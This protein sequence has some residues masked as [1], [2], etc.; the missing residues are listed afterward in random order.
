M[1][2][3][4]ILDIDGSIAEY[5]EDAIKL[6][7]ERDPKVCSG[8]PDLTLENKCIRRS[9]CEKE[10]VNI[11]SKIDEIFTPERVIGFKPIKKAQELIFRAK[12]SGK[13]TLVYYVSGRPGNLIFA[14]QQWLMD[15]RFP[16]GLI[17]LLGDQP[18]D[19]GENKV[20]FV[21]KIL[22]SADEK[23]KKELTL[24][25]IEDDVRVIKL[26]EGLGG[27]NLMG[28]KNDNQ[29]NCGAGC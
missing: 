27:I 26:Y 14:S 12:W 23:T 11:K 21:K 22:D 25:F 17:A 1:V 16:V 5:P 10:G 19:P 18:G 24:M 20:A 4:L 15:H 28:E 13:D 29:G 6:F 7:R 2:T 9:R 8:C 3:V